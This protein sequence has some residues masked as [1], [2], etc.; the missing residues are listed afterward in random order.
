MGVASICSSPRGTSTTDN[1]QPILV[2]PD[3][4]LWQGRLSPDGRWIAFNAQSRAAAGVSVIGVVPASGGTWTALTD[5]TIWADKPRWGPDGR[6]LYFISSRESAFFDVWGLR[7][8]PDTGQ[9]VGDE[10]RVTSFNDP[11]RALAATAASELGVGRSQ[12]VLPIVEATGSIWMLEA[13]P[14]P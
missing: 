7:F 10:F 9:A 1:V 4:S 14:Q 3:N 8:D 5:A 13:L 2:D 6:V 12:L 11:G